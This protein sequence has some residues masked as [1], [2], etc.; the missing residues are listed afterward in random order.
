MMQKEPFQDKTES[1]PVDKLV[2]AIPGRW[3]F[4]KEVVKSFDSHVRKSVPLYDEVQSLVI[5]MSEW[6]VRDGSV[7]Y[8]IGSSTG[9]TISLLLKKH[10]DKKNVLYVGVESVLSMIEAAQKKVAA[11]NVKFIHQDVSDMAEFA[12]ADLITSIYALQFLPLG[13]RKK[14]I[15]RVHDSLTEGGA[16]M[17]VEKIRAENS[18]FENMWAELH[19]DLKEMCG[20]SGDQI[21]QKAKSLRGVLT[22]LTLT[23]NINL[24]KEVGFSNVD[25]FIKWC[26]FAGLIAVKSAIPAKTRTKEARKSDLNQELLL[27]KET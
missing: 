18:H 6:F 4:N 14:V 12:N 10:F 5:E 1:K 23:E 27:D 3:E 26:N 22:P 2:T 11:K 9:E 20:L 21:I 19:Y 24:L 7:I 8:D 16:F 15:Q 17:L 13:K 25:V